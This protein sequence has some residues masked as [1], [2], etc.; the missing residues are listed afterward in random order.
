MIS[1]LQ[2]VGLVVAD[3]EAS[4]RFYADVL[5]LEQV[6]RPSSFTFD[7]AWFRVGADEVHLIA[8]RHTTQPDPPQDPGPGLASGLTTHMAFE[9]DDFGSTVARLQAQ[10]VVAAAGPLARG[11]GISQIYLRDPDGY[12]VELFGR[13]D[14]DQTGVER[15]PVVE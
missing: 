12:V 8:R 13:V 14:E 10:G 15:G 7:G 2:H 9:V 6:P 1:R 3:V 11:D 4:C 5:G